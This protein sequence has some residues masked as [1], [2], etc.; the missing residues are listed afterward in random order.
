M[1]EVEGRLSPHSSC[2]D[3]SLCPV[4]LLEFLSRAA[5][6]RIVAAHLFLSA[7]HLLHRLR[8]SRPSHTRLLQLAPLA[9]HKGFFQIVGR[10]GDE[11]WR[12]M[13][14]SATALRRHCRL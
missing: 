10:S 8:V 14:V 11:S 13:P 9:P 7:H 3:S 6:A 12:M 4:A 1:S 2:I 5:R